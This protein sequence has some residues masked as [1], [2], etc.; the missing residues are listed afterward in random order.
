MTL[1]CGGPLVSTLVSTWRRRGAATWRRPAGLVQRWPA[2]SILG[3][4]SV[5]TTKGYTHGKTR[6]ARDGLE[7][8]E[9]L[10]AV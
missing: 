5:L 7:R 3:H 9:H 2:R 1:T 6:L 8:M 4:V 10:V